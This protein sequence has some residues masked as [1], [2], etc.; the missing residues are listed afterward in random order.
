V[1]PLIIM[2]LCISVIS[3]QWVE[4]TGDA[5][6]IGLS[7]T[8]L[9]V[10]IAKK[11]WTGTGQ[12]AGSL[13]AQYLIVSALKYWIKEERPNRR[14]SLSFPSSHTSFAMTA[15]SF[16]LG[17]YGWRWGVPYL[18]LAGFTGY[19]RVYSKWHRWQDVIA[20]G[21]IGFSAGLSW[22]LL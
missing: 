19:S 15:A 7:A 1:K 4:R 14:D 20:G 8:A 2:A 9:S 16:M 22:G 5:L 6:A 11:D 3:A 10:T 18:S 13:V 17:R 21:A 12:L